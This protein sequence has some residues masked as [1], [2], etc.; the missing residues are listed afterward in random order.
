M[1]AELLNLIELD[2]TFLDKTASQ[3]LN[4]RHCLD[5]GHDSNK[6]YLESNQ[7]TNE[8]NALVKAACSTTDEGN[9]FFGLK[10][11]DWDSKMFDLKMGKIYP[12]IVPQ[13]SPGNSSAFDNGMAQ[14]EKL[15]EYCDKEGFQH[16]TTLVHPEDSMG[17]QLLSKCGFHLMDTTVMYELDIE[18]STYPF[19]Q[20]VSTRP[21]REED[22]STLKTISSTCFANRNNNINRF[23]SD[24]HLCP[25]KVAQLYEEWVI[26]SYTGDQ[27]DK[28]LVIEH[29]GEIAG[30]ISVLKASKSLYSSSKE[31]VQIPINAISPQFKGLGLYRKMV[32]HV[33]YLAKVDNEKKIQIWTH[34]SNTAVHRVWQSIGAK[35]IL[36]GHQMRRY[37]A[38]SF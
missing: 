26:N 14:L 4:C 8:N 3:W 32:E 28:L 27:A 22:L 6:N 34:I 11:L 24:P 29:Q 12:F 16:L 38:N 21:A 7:L 37:Q 30:F 13:V 25:Q 2:Q 35:L 17:I 10:A 33:I 5:I 36:S 23:N 18:S 20:C 1:P 31:A 15:L 19:T 9:W